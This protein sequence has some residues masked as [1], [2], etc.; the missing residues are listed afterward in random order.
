MQLASLAATGIHEK[1]KTPLR[2]EPAQWELR[3][4]ATMRS[5]REEQTQKLHR[6][7]QSE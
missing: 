4:K 5:W 7:S 2:K 6:V 1:R 3:L